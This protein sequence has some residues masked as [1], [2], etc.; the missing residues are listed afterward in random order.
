MTKIFEV[1]RKPLITEKSQALKEKNIQVFEVA[2]WASK[3][4]IKEA[5]ELLLQVKVKSIR[6]VR[7]PS[8]TKRVGRWV[9]ST[10]AGKK[11]YIELSGNLI[12]EA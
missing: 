5:A 12:Q 11:A 8:K 7:V 6:T 3:N 4:H 1:I 2:N 10:G 9:G